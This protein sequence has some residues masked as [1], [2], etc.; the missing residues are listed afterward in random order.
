M[1]MKEMRWVEKRKRT[2]KWMDVSWFVIISG[3]CRR[4]LNVRSNG[5]LSDRICVRV[6]TYQQTVT[7]RLATGTL[8]FPTGLIGFCRSSQITRQ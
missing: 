4:R 6:L 1:L 7:S 8:L 3:G 5:R 2:K